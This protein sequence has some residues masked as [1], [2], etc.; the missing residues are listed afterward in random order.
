MCCSAKRYIDVYV[1]H[2]PCGTK[3]SKIM[4]LTLNQATRTVQFQGTMKMVEPWAD[5]EPTV[6]A[7]VHMTGEWS[8]AKTHEESGGQV[9][10]GLVYSA[11]QID[12]CD[13]S[14]AEIERLASRFDDTGYGWFG[15][16]EKCLAEDCARKFWSQPR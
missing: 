13:V 2:N 1:K 14:P 12:G 11:M 15:W 5:R 4:N 9:T 8:E 3:P 7:V 10:D 6:V 16:R